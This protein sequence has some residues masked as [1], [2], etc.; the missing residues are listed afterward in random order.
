[1][2]V[3]HNQNEPRL[4]GENAYWGTGV[5][6]GDDTHWFGHLSSRMLMQSCKIVKFLH[7]SH[8]FSNKMTKTGKTGER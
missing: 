8:S 7:E 4:A 5:V 6:E 1:M 2:G 3:H